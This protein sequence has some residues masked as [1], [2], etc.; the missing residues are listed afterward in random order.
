MSRMMT[1]KD[2][3]AKEASNY[4]FNVE[5]NSSGQNKC[6]EILNI[7]FPNF[8]VRSFTM[9]F[10]LVCCA[11]FATTKIYATTVYG[12]K[13][14]EEWINVLHQFQAKYTYDITEKY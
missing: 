12:Q 8:Q 10:A 2:L 11:M 3:Q 6:K 7:I 14:E 13:S 9:L 4:G 5:R 1:L